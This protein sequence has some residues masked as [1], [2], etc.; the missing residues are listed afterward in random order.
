[1]LFKAK[2]YY[3]SED[4]FFMLLRTLKY[5]HQQLKSLSTTCSV[6]STST[7][8]LFLS[9]SLHKGQGV[10][11]EEKSIVHSFPRVKLKLANGMKDDGKG[12]AHHAGLV[13]V[14][15]SGNMSSITV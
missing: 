14:T 11:S 10:Y 15:G 1:M 4:N 8:M 9:P 5:L 2:N 12:Q 13:K 7:C 6:N 3:Y